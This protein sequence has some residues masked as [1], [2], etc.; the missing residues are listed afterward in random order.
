MCNAK[1]SRWPN[2]FRLRPNPRLKQ[3][4]G[5]L[6]GLCVATSAC[7]WDYEGHRVI[8]Q[9]ALDSL[10]ADFPSFVCLPAARERVAFLSGEPDRWRN[11]P[12]LAFKHL[13]NPDHYMDLEDLDL[14]GLDPLKLPV[15]RYDFVAK[16][17]RIRQSRPAMFPPVGRDDDHTAELVGFLPWSIVEHYG[18]LKSGFSYLKAFEEHGGTSEEIANAQANLVYVMGVMGHMVGDAGQPLHLTRHHHGWVGDNPNR[19]TTNRTIH[20]WIDGGY[21][22]KVGAPDRA[23]LGRQLR[24]ARLVELDGRSAKPAQMF[25]A[26]MVFLLEQY[27]QLE[28]LYQMEKEGK[29]SGNGTKGLLGKPFLEGRMVQSAQ[30]LGDLYFSAWQQATPDTFLINQLSKRSRNRPR[31]KP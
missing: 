9:L 22:G 18:K 5:L 28:P 29:L 23:A 26:V 27:K 4:M 16:L 2:A 20:S 14:Y 3:V 13:N 1:N 10:P 8:N 30:M 7:A 11:T 6:L 15:F 17:A 31:Q 12:D 25:Q 19:Y 24:P 21:F